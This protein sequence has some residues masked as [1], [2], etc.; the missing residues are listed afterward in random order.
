MR[1]GELAI[2][3]H[4]IARRL[5]LIAARSAPHQL[6]GTAAELS[7]LKPQGLNCEAPSGDDRMREDRLFGHALSRQARFEGFR[8]YKE[9]SGVN[10]GQSFDNERAAHKF[11]K[12]STNRG[13]DRHRHVTHRHS[14]LPSQE[15]SAL[16]TG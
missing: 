12:L 3:P 5:D 11:G 9:L 13:I 4:E 10:A 1:R 8:V 16:G 2:E 15:H 14:S 6:L 7:R